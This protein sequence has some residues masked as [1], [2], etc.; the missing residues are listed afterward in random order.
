MYGA[1]ALY[2]K[3]MEECDNFSDTD[4]RTEWVRTKDHALENP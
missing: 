4:A 2:E 3:N 1:C